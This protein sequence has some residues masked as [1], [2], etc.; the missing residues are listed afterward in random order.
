M[1][2]L[3]IDIASTYKQNILS[4]GSF[5]VFK[6]IENDVNPPILEDEYFVLNIF[7]GPLHQYS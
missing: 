6:L 1:G 5:I 3:F 4:G 7:V 2:V